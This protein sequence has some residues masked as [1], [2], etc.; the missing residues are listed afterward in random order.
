MGTNVTLSGKPI[1]DA[2]F[3]NSWHR[4][5]VGHRTMPLEIPQNLQFI[6]GVLGSSHCSLLSVWHNEKRGERRS[7]LPSWFTT[8]L[9]RWPEA[10]P[11]AWA[12][13]Q[14]RSGRRLPCPTPVRGGSNPQH[15][16]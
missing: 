12:P 13:Q 4:I 7:T 16:P 8:S 1:W 2:A 6:P 11:E 3:G 5:V 9:E 14:E 15:V 10:W